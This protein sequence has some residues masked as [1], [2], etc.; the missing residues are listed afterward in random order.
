MRAF[1][2]KVTSS[3]KGLPADEQAILAK[4]WASGPAITIEIKFFWSVDQVYQRLKVLIDKSTGMVL[5]TGG[6]LKRQAEYPAR[7]AS[8]S[9]S[10]MASIAAPFPHAGLSPS[11]S[12]SGA[13]PSTAQR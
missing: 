4:V 10:R 2:D 1:Y 9:W 8:R 12:R 3:I 13:Y 5:R 7:N 6:P 11:A